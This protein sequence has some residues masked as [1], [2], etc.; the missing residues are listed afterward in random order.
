M[1]ILFTNLT[2][3]Y[4]LLGLV[5]CRCLLLVS[6]LPPLI[7]SSLLNVVTFSIHSFIQQIFIQCL[8]YTKHCPVFWGPSSEKTNMVLFR[9]ENKVWWR[10]HLKGLADG[11]H[12]GAKEGWGVMGDSQPSDLGS[13]V[14]GAAIHWQQM[15]FCCCF[16]VLLAWQGESDKLHF[17][18]VELQGLLGHLR[19]NVQSA[20]GYTGLYL[21]NLSESHPSLL[22]DLNLL[23]IPSLCFK[24]FL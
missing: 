22:E 19:G 5:I 16:G 17:R 6:V 8:Q 1:L 12:V 2:V 21:F 14:D 10:R 4:D 23:F 3:G 24:F 11:L 7:T 13:W 20:V 9:V 15:F 18:C